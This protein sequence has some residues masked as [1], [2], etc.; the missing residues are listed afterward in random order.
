[1]PAFDIGDA[2][3]IQCV[4]QLEGDGRGVV[5]RNEGDLRGCVESV[6]AGINLRVQRHCLHI[7]ACARLL[8]IL[9]HA[10]NRQNDCNQHQAENLR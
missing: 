3:Q 7:D 2:R 4:I 10:H 1:M 9:G 5:Q 6:R 8:A